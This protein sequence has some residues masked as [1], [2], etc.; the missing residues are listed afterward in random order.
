M[1]CRLEDERWTGPERVFDREEE[2]YFNADEDGDVQVISQPN[3]PRL[4]D[5]PILLLANNTGLKRKRRPG[6]GAATKGYRP[7]LKPPQMQ[8]SSLV[9]YGEDEEEESTSTT[10]SP[11]E[12]LPSLITAS[13]SSSSLTPKSPIIPANSGPPPKRTTHEE[14]E[15]NLLEALAR[16]NRSRP[17]T[18]GPPGPTSKLGEKRRREDEDEDDLLFRPLPKLSKKPDLGNQK[19]GSFVK[20]KIGEDPPASKKIKVKLGTIGRSVASSDPPTIDSAGAPTSTSQ[21]GTK[22]GD[23]G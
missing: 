10:L 12:A 19:E 14:E 22:D 1:F 17:Q 5:T 11:N 7:P 21:P 4:V 6:V 8:L 3:R 9:D 13:A 18:P 15:D 20:R 23:T 16:N 2:A